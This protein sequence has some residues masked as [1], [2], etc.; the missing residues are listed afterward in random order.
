[1]AVTTL[2]C[3]FCEFCVECWVH[4]RRTS[5]DSACAVNPSA[6][7]SGTMV[8]RSLARPALVTH[9]TAITRMK[10]AALSPPR[11]RAAPKDVSTASAPDPHTPA[12]MTEYGSQQT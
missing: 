3:D 2:L 6:R 5:I 11:N 4:L 1:M 12:A 9:C 8:G 10:P 7:A